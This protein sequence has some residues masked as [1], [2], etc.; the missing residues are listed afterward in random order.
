MSALAGLLDQQ[1]DIAGSL[2]QSGALP[3]GEESLFLG[4]AITG[5]TG[6]AANVIAGAPAGQARISGLT[7]MTAESLHKFLRLSGAASGGNNGEFLIVNHIDANT[8][9][10]VNASAVAPD[11]NNGSITWTERQGYSLEDN[12]NYTLSDRA[13]I[14]GVAFDAA[15][16]TYVRPTAIGS[17]VDKSLTNLIS[18]DSKALVTDREALGEAVAEGDTLVTLSDAGNLTHADAVDRTGV[19]IQDGADAGVFEASYVEIYDPATGQPLTLLGSEVGDFTTVAASL[20][21][22]GA[23][24]DFV[25]IDDGV[26]TPTVFVFDDDG[27]HA[28]TEFSRS[29]DH[30]G[31]ET[32]DFIRDALVAAI[33]AAPSLLVTAV[34]G[35]AATVNFTHANPGVQAG[36]VATETVANAGFLVSDFAGGDA[37]YGDRVY[38]ITFAGSATEPNEVEVQFF[39]VAPGA[40][41]S[42]SNV[43]TWERDQPTSVNMVYGFRERMDSMSDVA[44]R[45]RLANGLVGDAGLSQRINDLQDVLSDLLADGVTH[46]GGLLTPTTNFFAWSDL[47]DATPDV[48][49]A[50]N[51]LNTE[52]GNRDY[53]GAILTDGETITASL[54]ALSD[55][56]AGSNFTRVIQVLTVAVAVGAVLTIPSGT[57]TPDSNSGQNLILFWRKELR[58]PGDGTEG[59]HDYDETSSTTVTVYNKV[60]V[61]D[62]AEW[63]V[64]A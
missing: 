22:V 1:I 31:T 5:Q 17:N 13:N 16:P 39:H 30:T 2:N 45:R 27:S 48:V 14:K 35:G 23:D 38:G 58:T 41:L 3:Y 63:L 42:V 18:L 54:Q 33:L 6:V 26:N 28:E 19:P 46:L 10:V 50:L 24:T 64:Y 59:G 11:A 40:A 43:Y 8:V 62:I 52:I 49:E 4:A 57:Y 20:L 61:G 47:P 44:L 32:A 34:S 53:T 9:D 21:A 51:V 36:A 25:T 55:A 56:V 7:G 12:V 37:D 29:V 60:K 15:I